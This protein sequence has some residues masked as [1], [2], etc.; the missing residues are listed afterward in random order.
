MMNLPE[1]I[2]FHILSRL[3]TKSL[4]RF[5]C[6]CKS[7]YALLQDHTF[8]LSHTINIFT[9]RNINAND[10]DDN[11][12]T[13]LLIMC[14]GNS[15][16]KR[17][18]LMSTNSS[19]ET[20][21]KLENSWSFSDNYYGQMRLIGPCHGIVC[22]YGYPD[23]IAL[24]N[25]SIN[26]EFKNLPVSVI[27]RPVDAKVRGGDVGLGY[28]PNTD[29]YKVIQILFCIS[30][31]HGLV[32]QVEIYS[33]STNSWRKYDAN[34]PANVMYTN[35]WSMV[36]KSKNFCWWAKNDDCEMILSFDMEKEIFQETPLPYD[37]EE[38]GGEKRTTRAIIPWNEKISLVVYHVKEMD[39]VFDI[40]IMREL[41]SGGVGADW[42]KLSRIGPI[43]GVERPLGFWKNGEFIL[44]NRYRELVLYDPSR[45][46]IKNL[47][48]YGKRD[49]LEMLVYYPSIVSINKYKSSSMDK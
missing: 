40:W 17:A 15:T 1:D 23:K 14:R 43:V 36:Y 16:D 25:P 8:I 29:D 24:C 31:H 2:I 22:L 49:R 3:P 26:N 27:P 18:I 34:V 33:L 44:E 9:K 32:Y 19:L 37:I 46:E 7:W 38:F 48:L 45:N 30:S 21:I 20:F 6:V 13:H 35:I 41:G 42:T 28:D 47:G 10:N 12:D 4:I 5:K 11:D 39:K